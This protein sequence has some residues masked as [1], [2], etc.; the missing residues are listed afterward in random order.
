MSIKVCDRS[1]SESAYAADTTDL[2]LLYFEIFLFLS[3]L[4]LLS[5][6]KQ[7]PSVYHCTEANGPQLGSDES[8]ALQ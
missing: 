4:N 8:T 5:S 2:N 3:Y 7:V 1:V 6:T